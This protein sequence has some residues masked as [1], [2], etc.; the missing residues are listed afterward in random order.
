MA[1][2]NASPAP[3][4]AATK[5]SGLL[6]H[7]GISPAAFDDTIGLFNPLLTVHRLHAKVVERI[8]ETPSALSLVLETGPAFRGIRPGQYLMLDVV[9]RGVR[10]RRAYSPRA[11]A[12]HPNRIAV[13]VQRQPGGLVSG[14]IHDAL[15]VGQVIEIEQAAGDFTLPANLPERLLLIAGGSGITPSM[16]MIQH[17][18]A[19]GARTQVT[20]IYFARSAQDRIFGKQL[21]AIAQSWPQLTYVP[22]DSVANTAPEAGRTG[23]AGAATVLDRTLLEQHCPMWAQSEA[24]CCGPAPLMDAARSLWAEAGATQRLH[25]EAFAA[26]RPN[27][28]PNARH[29]V[30]VLRAGSAQQFEA[31]GNQTLLV[32]GEAAGKPL[33]H[34]CRQGIC[35][36]CSCR[37]NQGAVKDLLS[38]DTV[39]AEGQII[40][41]CVTTALTDLDLESLL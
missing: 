4:G 11:V 36:Q 22:L 9:I 10:H 33:P 31:A 41:V 7:L 5:L 6:T 39:T 15:R 34:G 29:Q 24:Y 17:L 35:N 12:G 32:A 20:L 37:L 1:S 23:A 28:D 25:L 16:A 19:T 18:Q 26:P 2:S 38:G 30:R 14:H 8:Q 27:G 21:A 13:T 40:R 3:A